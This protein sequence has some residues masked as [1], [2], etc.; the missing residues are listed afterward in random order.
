MSKTKLS[1]YFNQK[2][3]QITTN[4]YKNPYLPEC[5]ILVNKQLRKVYGNKKNKIYLNNDDYIQLNIFNPT[6]ERIGVQLEFNGSIENKMLIVN[7][8]QKILLDRFV[9]TKKKIKFSTYFVDGDNKISKKAIE[10]NGSIKI[11][12]WKE[13]NHFAT[14]GT[15]NWNNTFTTNSIYSGTLSDN[16]TMYDNELRSSIGISGISGVSGPQDSNNL[17]FK[18]SLLET[19]RLEKG[20]KSKQKME[21]VYFDSDYIFYTQKFKL[22]PFSQMKEK[23]NQFQII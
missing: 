7:P 23:K 1:D 20:D 11:H 8:G 13:K 16:T 14:S 22:L 2:P 3:Y 6:F 17:K 18:E 12:F 15:I 9:D 21:E 5:E 4:L 10:K 19:G